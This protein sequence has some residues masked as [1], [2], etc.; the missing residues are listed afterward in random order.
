M[1]QVR[2][3]KKWPT[4]LR[5]KKQLTCVFKITEEAMNDLDTIKQIAGSNVSR[6]L[7]D[8]KTST[9]Y[10]YHSQSVGIIDNDFIRKVRTV[11]V[12]F[13]AI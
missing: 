5:N 4:W 1:K 2:K 7:I 8:F 9:K 11:R 3:Y 10:L 12:K 6:K 13:K